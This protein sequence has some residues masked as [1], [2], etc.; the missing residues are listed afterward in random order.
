MAIAQPSARSA[1]SLDS[2]TGLVDAVIRRQQSFFDREVLLADQGI[3]PHADDVA[4][5]FLDVVRAWMNWTLEN[6]HLLNVADA[7]RLRAKALHGRRV[8]QRP[9]LSTVPESRVRRPLRPASPDRRLDDV[10]EQRR[11]QRRA[12]G[13]RDGSD[14]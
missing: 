12:S 6:R 8:T 4:G 3:Q 11:T 5:G 1:L 2:S 9:H 14:Q 7:D 10:D 13:T